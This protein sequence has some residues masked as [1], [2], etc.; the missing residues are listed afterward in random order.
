MIVGETKEFNRGWKNCQRYLERKYG[1]TIAL[2][3]MFMF[4]LGFAAGMMS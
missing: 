3:G 4:L 1:T 2:V